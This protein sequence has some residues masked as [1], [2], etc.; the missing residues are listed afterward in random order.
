MRGLAHV[1]L[2]QPLRG[3]LEN[4][5]FGR[6]GI[7]GAE[8]A[9]A[10]REPAAAKLDVDEMTP[11]RAAKL[12]SERDVISVALVMPMKLIAPVATPAAADPLTN[13]STWGI[14]AVRADVS[15]FTGAGIIPAVLDTGIAKDH[16][17][18]AGVEIVGRN[19][20]DGEENDVTDVEGHGTHCAGTIFGRGVN[21]TRIGVAPGITKA[22][23]GKVLGEN[24]GS[25]DVLAR[26]ITWA[27]E[28]GAN[29]ISM[30]IGID[31]P[32]LVHD[33]EG[34]AYPTELATSIALEGYR[35][36]V[37]LFESLVRLATARG[38][39]N[40]PPCIIVAAAGN[41]SRRDE[42]PK[43]EIAVSPPAVSE[44]VVSVAALGPSAAGFEV[45]S[46]SNTGALVSGPG[47][48]VLSANKDGGLVAMS[49]TSMA[50]PHVAGVAA[51]WAEKLTKN[52]QFRTPLFSTK[53]LGSAT[54]DGLAAGFAPGNVGGG[55]VI[56]PL[57]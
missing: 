16:P 51:L 6:R 48:G 47:V 14:K 43:F 21:G 53:V 31:F 54:E 55:I 37:M 11:A 39:V 33:L 7:P 41:E 50:T 24:G 44:G 26:A 2:R 30:S 49:G 15:P 45:A 27:M 57:N 13:G 46:F 4:A 3:G 8:M 29:V 25:S 22:L 20:T 34:D 35:K 12:Q 52:A 5:V 10:R 1:V 40:A 38:G 9:D 18:F 17:A 28:N 42:D 19:F 23:I 36:N 56:A 32:G